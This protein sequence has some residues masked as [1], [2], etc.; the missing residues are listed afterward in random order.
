MMWKPSVKAICSL[1]GKSWSGSA[2]AARNKGYLARSTVNMDGP[3]SSQV[4]ALSG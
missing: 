1:A 2:A 3:S 4:Q